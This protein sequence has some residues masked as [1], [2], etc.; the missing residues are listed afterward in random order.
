[1]V[2]NSATIMMII[3]LENDNN[4]SLSSSKNNINQKYI[5]VNLIV[6]EMWCFRVVIKE[7][8]SKSRNKHHVFNLL[9]LQSS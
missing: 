1:M 4:N 8:R 7:K 2:V 9:N 6:L 5:A 3:K